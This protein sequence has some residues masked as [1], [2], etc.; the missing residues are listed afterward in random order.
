MNT[1]LGEPEW[2]NWSEKKWEQVEAEDAAVEA[3]RL[4]FD[5]V[6]MLHE[7][8]DKHEEDWHRHHE[9]TDL[10]EQIT[11]EIYTIRV[12]LADA[13]IIPRPVDPSK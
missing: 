11:H 1:E 4:L 5:E 10:M 13:G 9:H 3:G 6:C 8:L 2:V 7:P 12:R